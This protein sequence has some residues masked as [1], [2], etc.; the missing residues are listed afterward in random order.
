MNTSKKYKDISFRF[1][2]MD[3]QDTLQR[4]INIIAGARS[5]KTRRQ[6]SRAEYFHGIFSTLHKSNLRFLSIFVEE[7]TESLCV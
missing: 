6:V 4:T 2:E 5:I 7:G 3:L 1:T